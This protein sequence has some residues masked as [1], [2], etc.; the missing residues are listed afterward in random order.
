LVLSIF[1]IFAGYVCSEAYSGIGSNLWANS[2]YINAM[3][4]SS[5]EAEF[6]LF[7][8]KLLPL[9]ISIL[10]VISYM[11]IINKVSNNLLFLNNKF[12][13]IHFFF[14]K[15]MMF[16]YLYNQIMYN[17][18]LFG[19]YFS[20]YKKLE[21]GF[22]EFFG[23]ILVSR[24]LFIFWNIFSKL[25]TGLVYN[26][27]FNMIFVMT[28]FIICFELAIWI[29][30]ISVVICLLFGYIIQIIFFEDMDNTNNLNNVANR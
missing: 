15:A 30:N 10:G 21:K 19:S 29:D 1:S 13:Q 5:F 26:Y 17:Y 11:L 6:D 2:I 24:F 20:F 9:F 27:V 22:F 14:N 28:L 8:I 25:N 16:D 23:P 12:Y 7:I 18:F 3:N 4:F